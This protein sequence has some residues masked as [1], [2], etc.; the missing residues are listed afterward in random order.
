M[1]DFHVWYDIVPWLFVTVAGSVAYTLIL[2][3]AVWSEK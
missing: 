3:A 2:L 1:F